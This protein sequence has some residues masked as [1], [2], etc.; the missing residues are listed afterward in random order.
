MKEIFIQAI[1]LLAMGVAFCS[2]QQKSQ[3][4]ILVLQMVSTTLFTLHFGLLGAMSGCLLNGIGIVRA[5]VY[6]Q[7]DKKWGA[8]VAWPIVFSVLAGVCY[9]L[10]FVCFGVEPTFKNLLLELLPAAATVLTNVALR[11]EK[12]AA[13]R[14][15]CM[16][17]SPLWFVYNAVAGS[18]GGMLTET[19]NFLSI[20]IGMLRLD[21]KKAK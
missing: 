2:F 16:F 10:N 18:L 7:R 3:K 19:F 15:L 12:A 1:G 21:R 11:C 13:V 4:G 6:S 14:L 8:H 20:V 5:A 17:N 9:A